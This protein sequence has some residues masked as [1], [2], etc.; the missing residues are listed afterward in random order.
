MKILLIDNYHYRRGG[1]EVVYFNTGDILSS[2]GH[3]IL[4]FSQLWDEN[5]GCDYDVYF[6]KGVDIRR[7][8]AYQKIIG[9]RN[10]VFNTQAAKLLDKLIK[11]THPD[12]AHVHLFW[13]G[14][15]TSI[16]K[17]LNRNGIPVVHTVHDYRMVCPAYTF[18]DGKNHI[19]EKCHAGNYI[20]CI[21]NKCAK[22][23]LLMGAIMTGEMYFRNIFFHPSKYISTFIYVS[24]FCRDKHIEHDERF[25]NCPSEIIYNFSNSDILHFCE[26]KKENVNKYSNYYLYYGR[27]S[28][29][30]GIPTLIDAFAEHKDLNLKIVG[31]GPEET[32]LKR[33]CY[34][35]NINNIEFLGYK[36]GRELYDIIQNAKFVCVPSE[37]YENNP[38]TI[39]ESYTLGTP[40]IAAEIGGIPEIVV[41]NKTGFLFISADKKS[42]SDAIGKA[43]SID[44]ETYMS[45]CENA[46]SFAKENFSIDNYY[47]RLMDVYNRTLNNSKR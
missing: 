4:Y 11:D 40:V 1:A 39:I 20:S 15:S 44:L 43:Q 24:K 38:M 29:E 21:L 8:T 18:K 28:Y 35:R 9:V 42:L 19:C 25:L 31:T 47:N 6:P 16:L 3:K 12:I 26:N 37:W 10:Y 36:T 33:I 7:S 30:K 41:N 14:L 34:D 27:L 46:D 32:E 22:G 5:L 23:N 2:H 17:V 45:L 13:G